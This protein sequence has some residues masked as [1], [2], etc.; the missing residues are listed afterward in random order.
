MAGL[1]FGARA[2]MWHLT[3]DLDGQYETLTFVM[4]HYKKCY[5]GTGVVTLK[6]DGRKL[7]DEKVKG[8]DV[9]HNYSVNVKGV[10][11]LTFAIVAGA[12]DVAVA[13]AV[14]WKSGWI[15]V[16]ADDKIIEEIEV[17]E[18]QIARQVTLDIFH[19]RDKVFGRY[20]IV[21]DGVFAR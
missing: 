18:G 9:P 17:K 10:R 16:K 2:H 6:A 13:D 11:K 21:L 1:L 12:M 3:F 20:H 15:T 14:L 8:Y 4:G 5:D 19:G 7:L